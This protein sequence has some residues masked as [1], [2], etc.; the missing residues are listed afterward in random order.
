MV[1]VICLEREKHIAHDIS[2]VKG[3]H[4]EECIYGKYSKLFW[5][6]VIIYVAR[7]LIAIL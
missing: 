2:Q 1:E 5:F 6:M 4:E 3:L 7:I